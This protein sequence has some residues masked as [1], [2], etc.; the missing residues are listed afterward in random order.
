MTGEEALKTAAELISIDR[1]ATYGKA[2]TDFSATAKLVT[3]V[4]N[5]KGL[6]KEGAELDAHCIA[7]IM[8]CVKLSR[9]AN[10]HK[11]DNCIDGAGY[12]ALAMDVVK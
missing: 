9:E 4:L 8:V 11:E 3:V 7:L 12:F 5:R 1:Q 10:L 2:V 6:L